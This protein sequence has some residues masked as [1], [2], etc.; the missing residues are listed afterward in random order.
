MMSGRSTCLFLS[1]VLG[2]GI[3]LDAFAFFGKVSNSFQSCS[4]S[5]QITT[6]ITASAVAPVVSDIWW[7]EGLKFGCTACGRCCQNE[8]EV[9][10]DADEF[11]DLSTNLKED[12][13]DVL[14]KYAEKTMSGWV[15]M[16]N[17]VSDDPKI[18]DRCI[19]L[20]PDGKQCSIYESRPIQC[21]T[22]PF[23]PRLLS[24]P[25]EWAKEAVQPDTVLIEEGSSERHWAPATGGCEGKTE[26][27]KENRIDKLHQL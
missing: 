25:E 20:G 14:D 17:Q 1:V 13:Q 9:W 11:A 2:N 12:P 21:R 24:T 19:F 4:P 23:W 7:K 15:K 5:R 26:C 27:D 8:G 6:Q 16:K 10:L 22:Y 3:Y 18:S